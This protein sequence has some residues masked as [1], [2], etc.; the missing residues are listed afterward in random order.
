[1]VTRTDPVNARACDVNARISMAL[2][3]VNLSGWQF[4]SS[5]NST[6]AV[7]AAAQRLA[8][9]SLA[10]C[11]TQLARAVL[12]VWAAALWL[13][14]SN[15]SR[16]CKASSTWTSFGSPSSRLLASWS[17]SFR[18][19]TCCHKLRSWSLKKAEVLNLNSAAALALAADALPRQRALYMI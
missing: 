12:A 14:G 5:N 17:Q 9:G 6:Q 19:S 15:C 11:V 13:Q 10:L 7:W 8:W 3:S 2:T 4:K 1:M 16:A 18:V